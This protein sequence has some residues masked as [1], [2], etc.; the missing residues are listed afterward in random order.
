MKRG[1]GSL[2]STPTKS[3]TR[4]TMPL[5]EQLLITLLVVLYSLAGHTNSQSHAVESDHGA[6]SCR[7]SHNFTFL[8]FVPCLQ[9]SENEVVPF[10]TDPSDILTDRLLDDCDLLA[11]VAM[12][13]AIEKVNED[14]S[15]LPNSFLKKESLFSHSQPTEHQTQDTFLV[16]LT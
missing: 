8:V 15:I 10:S 6:P 12:R 2:E 14:G 1:S 16:S 9:G 11:G 7:H 5:L 4:Q 13:L 3:S